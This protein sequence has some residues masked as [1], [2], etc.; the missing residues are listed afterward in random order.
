LE[1][2]ITLPKDVCISKELNDRQLEG[3]RIALLGVLNQS[4]PVL[5]GGS[6]GFLE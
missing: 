1:T 5:V 4:L 3:A 6:K 2:T